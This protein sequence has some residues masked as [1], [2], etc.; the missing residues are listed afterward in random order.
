MAPL[1]EAGPSG[2]GGGGGGPL[3]DGEAF[4]VFWRGGRA[5]RRPRWA[6]A[7]RVLPW[8]TVAVAV[9]KPGVALAG[10]A[11]LAGAAVVLA[12]SPRLSARLA[13]AAVPVVMASV[14]T[15]L[16][17][18]RTDLLKGLRGRVLDVGCGDAPYLEYARGNPGLE[19]YVCLEPNPGLQEAIRARAGRLG[20]QSFQV[21]QVACTLEE[22]PRG[23]AGYLEGSFD[24]VI[25]GN[26]LCELPD[27]AAALAQCR[28][29]LRPGGRVYFCEHVL[30]GESPLRRALQHAINP[31]WRVVSDGCNCN[32]DSVARLQ[33]AF[34]AGNVLAQ[35]VYLDHI[36]L[37]WLARFE[38]GLAVRRD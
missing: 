13:A 32:R 33:E 5:V 17:D 21:E 35:T 4:G 26:V 2:R 6:A 37:P 22:L 18:L 28:R 20:P 38:L 23:G 10:A 7:G 1:E 25:L 12:L 31:W 34:G 29:L 3:F 9:A 36:P 27:P 24:A 16:R 30:D 19:L 11:G 15:A 14:D 8:V